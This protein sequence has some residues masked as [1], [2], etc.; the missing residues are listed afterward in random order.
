MN[1]YLKLVDKEDAT[2]TRRAEP[3]PRVFTAPVL[4]RLAR[5]NRAWRELRC[6]GFSVR[7]ITWA[8]SGPQLRIERLSNRSLKPLLDRM[9]PRRF[10]ASGAGTEVSGEFEG[11]TVC[12]LQSGPSVTLAAAPR[13]HLPL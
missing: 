8:E 5:T 4:D 9:G 2:P 12:W 10:S 11:V 6:M 13:Y 7:S 3:E 1:G